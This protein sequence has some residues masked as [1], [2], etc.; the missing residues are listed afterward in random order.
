MNQEL[1]PRMTTCNSTRGDYINNV[2]RYLK[3]L[4][5]GTKVEIAKVSKNPEEFTEAVKFIIDLRMTEVVFTNDYKCI[6]KREEISYDEHNTDKRVRDA[7][8][9]QR[10]E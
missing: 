1:D 3:T 4:A 8:S 5:P 2:Y 9:T 6:I 10:A 7:G